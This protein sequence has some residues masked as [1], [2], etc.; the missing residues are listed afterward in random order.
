[1]KSSIRL[2]VFGLVAVAAIL[3]VV[4]N[5]QEAGPGNVRQPGE[6][7]GLPRLVSLGAGK[8]IPCC[9]MEPVRAAL[10]EEY[11]GRL[12][13]EYYDVWENPQIGE[14]YGVY[15]IPTLI[16]YGADGRELGRSEGY[17]DNERILALWRRVGVDLDAPATPEAGS[18]AADG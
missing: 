16:I 5:R 10:R 12:V 6:A 7:L 15:A 14:L 4:V 18:G 1:M 3:I 9:Q 8:C 17:M 13:V 11:A 2:L